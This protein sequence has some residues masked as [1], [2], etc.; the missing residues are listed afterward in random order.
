[1]MRFMRRSVISF[2]RYGITSFVV[3]A[4]ASNVSKADI[5]MSRCSQLLSSLCLAATHL[6]RYDG[7]AA[8]S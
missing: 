7:R 6:K 5:D 8:R 4:Y 3:L 2:L 1:M